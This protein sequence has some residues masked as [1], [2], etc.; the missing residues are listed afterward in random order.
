MDCCIWLFSG[1]QLG[2]LSS[3]RQTHLIGEVYGKTVDMLK[4]NQHCLL[5]GEGTQTAVSVVSVRHFVHPDRQPPV[6]E[7][8]PC[9]NV[10]LLSP[11][12]QREDRLQLHEYITQENV[13]IK[14]CCHQFYT[15]SI[16][17]D[18]G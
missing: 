9:C 6:K 12:L 15:I 11:F 3:F 13:I 8:R 16:C 18:L 10:T 5:T 4:R 7:V 2:V 14:W 1:L 17:T